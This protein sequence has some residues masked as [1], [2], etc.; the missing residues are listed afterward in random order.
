MQKIKKYSVWVYPNSLY[1]LHVNT[2]LWQA[3]D[4]AHA[5]VSEK[6]PCQNKQQFSHHSNLNRKS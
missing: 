6:R 5:E 3:F 2:S 4:W 1:H